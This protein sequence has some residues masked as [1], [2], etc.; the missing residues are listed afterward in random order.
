[1]SEE[2][3]ILYPILVGILHFIFFVVVVALVISFVK[4]YFPGLGGIF[5]GTLTYVIIFGSLVALMATLTAY[6]IRGTK[7]RMVSGVLKAGSMI[8]YHLGIYNSLDI[9]VER[10][11]ALVSVDYPGM[12]LL[13]VL[14][15]VLYAIYFVFEFILHRK[16][17][18]KDVEQDEELATRKNVRRKR[19]ERS[20]VARDQSHWE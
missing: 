7:A 8:I 15:L 11:G 18:E 10:R 2:K 14:L 12:R 5:Q 4:D 16:D 6:F 1:M 9:T 17:S 13:V 20:N 19:D 3:P